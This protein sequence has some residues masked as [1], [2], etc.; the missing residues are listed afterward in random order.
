MD[1]LPIISAVLALITFLLLIIGIHTC[2]RMMAYV[3]LL[4]ALVFIVTG[5]V[6]YLKKDKPS[7]L[8]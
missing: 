1:R 4:L 5:L 3:C 7:A 2:Q 6:A 8:S